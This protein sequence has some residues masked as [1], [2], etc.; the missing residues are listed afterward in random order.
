MPEYIEA[1][2]HSIEAAILRK[3][4]IA[5]GKKNFRA[6]LWRMTRNPY[7]ILMS[8]VMLHR[9]QAEQVVPVY[10]QFIQTYPDVESLIQTTKEDLHNILY[11]LG[12]SWRINLIYEMG[13]ELKVRFNGMIPENKTDLLSLPG[14][15]EYIA[16]A[17]RCFAWNL[18]ES[19][20]D[21]NTVRVTGRLFG[22]IIKDSSRRNRQ[23]RDLL[24]AMVDTVN[25]R[26]YNYALLDLADKVCMKRQK[27][28]CLQCPLKNWCLHSEQKPDS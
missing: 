27:P 6:F 13:N 11:S 25:P 26:D 9:T 19:L 21:T 10:E 8:E 2:T 7:K 12:L 14:V 20:A 22:L 17:V 3:S 15:S 16:G 28:L 1:N 5:W 23:F 18:P 24:T 4:L